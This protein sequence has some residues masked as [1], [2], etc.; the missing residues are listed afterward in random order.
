[1]VWIALLRAVNVGGRKVDMRA[2]RDMAAGLGLQRPRTLLQSGNLLFE[3]QGRTAAQ[4]EA[5]LDAESSARLGL[6]VDFMVRSADEWA[7]LVAANPF[8]DEAERDPGHLLALVLKAPVSADVVA[9]LQ[10]AIAG[11][12]TVRGQGRAVY[13]C[14]PD[15][16]GASKLTN[17]I[18]ERKLGTRATGRNWNT[19]LKLLELSRDG[20]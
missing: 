5:L 14:Y 4:L 20:G 3:D 1:M 8:P 2:L 10:A 18:I 9:G 11:R 13:A 12:E 19:V 15:G 16:I 6:P 17:A 7:A